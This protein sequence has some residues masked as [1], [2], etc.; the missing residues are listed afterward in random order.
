MDEG[1]EWRNEV[2]ADLCSKSRIKIHFQ[3]VGA[4]PWVLGRCDGPAR[5]IYN[6]LMADGRGPGKQL[7]SEVQWCRSAL[8]SVGAY[9]VCHM[10]FGSTQRTFSVGAPEMG[11]YYLH[12]IPHSPGN[13][14]GSRNF[15]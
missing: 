5:G 11:T 6:F 13:S 7:P 3:G 9:P 14:R 4:R 15:A 2:W 1:E 8:I 12:R 10:G